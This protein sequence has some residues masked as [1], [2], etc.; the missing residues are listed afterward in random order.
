MLQIKAALERRGAVASL[1]LTLAIETAGSRGG[2]HV[3]QPSQPASRACPDIRRY[4]KP[5][6]TT[7]S[8]RSVFPE[9]MRPPK[10]NKVETPWYG[11]VCPVVWEGWRREASPYPDPFDTDRSR[12]AVDIDPSRRPSVHNRRLITRK[13]RR[14]D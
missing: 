8:S 1:S 9:S 7:I 3:R 10:P 14:R 5:Y 11:P 12:P 2:D 4:N 6:A 13:V